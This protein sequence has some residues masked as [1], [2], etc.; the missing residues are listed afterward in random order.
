MIEDY[1]FAKSIDE[2]LGFLADK[3]GKAKVF[4]GG[5]ALLLDGSLITGSPEYYLSLAKLN[6]LTGISRENG[7]VTIGAN[8]TLGQCAEDPLITENAPA[9]A[10]A[11]GNLGSTQIRNMATVAGNICAAKPFGDAP[12]ALAALDA[13]CIV[14]SAGG[15]REVPITE[16]Y[17][18][19][20][21]SIV[22]STKEVLTHIKFAARAGGEGFAFERLEPR[23]GLSFPIVNV[24]VKLRVADGVIS[25]AAIV[26]GPLSPGPRRIPA[27]EEFLI[28][29]TTTEEN[30]AQAG[31]LAS[32]NVTFHNSPERCR[33]HHDVECTYET[34]R[35]CVNP[36]RASGAY[37]HQV[38]PVLVRRA[39]TQAAHSAA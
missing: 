33:A 8:T 36:V 23:K 7:H 17:A 18:K 20:G 28:G 14:R 10:Q 25:E 32:Q 22:D 39:L 11:T 13:K 34:C 31:E 16:M 1:V 26:A 35:F 24:A 3:A 2:A 27:A 6:E 12:I 29:K 37:R 5:T 4:A 21:E 19:L 30:F 9:L 38:L 15:S